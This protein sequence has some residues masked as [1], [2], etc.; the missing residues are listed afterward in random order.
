ME[1]NKTLEKVGSKLETSV[2]QAN[3]NDGNNCGNTIT[4]PSLA[5]NW[6]PI[7][8]YK[9]T[10]Q[11]V[12]PRWDH[13]TDSVSVLGKER[14]N[15]RA[16]SFL[17]ASPW[18]A[19]FTKDKIWTTNPEVCFH[20]QIL[21]QPRVRSGMWPLFGRW[22]CFLVFWG[23]GF[24]PEKNGALGFPKVLLSS[25]SSHFLLPYLRSKSISGKRTN[26]LSTRRSG[27]RRDGAACTYART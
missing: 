3:K 25:M 20:R 14:A 4:K 21:F 24:S 15:E 12:L 16:A 8:V 6:P 5:G 7:I 27:T 1:P 22:V 26:L 18:L 10:E 2:K 13:S 11:P 17:S 19:F 23:G 9:N